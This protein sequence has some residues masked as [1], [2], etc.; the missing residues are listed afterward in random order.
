MTAAGTNRQENRYTFKTVYFEATR[1][2]NLSCPMCMAGSNNR[3]LV[4]ESVKKQLR[5]EE[6]VNHIL[7]PAR[8]IGV[9]TIAWSGG[10]FTL[11]PD[12]VHLV[13]RAAENGFSSGITTNCLNMTEDRL[14]QF[15]IASG[16]TLMISV[17]IDSLGNENAETRD[18]KVDV[19]L[20]V[21]EMCKELGIRSS[22]VVTVGQ[23][24]LGTLNHT[25]QWLEDKR[26]P[27][28]RIPF[29]P[30]GSATGC[31]DMCLTR[32]DMETVIHPA[33]RKR[34]MGYASYTPL[35]L[36]PEVYEQYARGDGGETV[37]LDPAIGCR[38]GACLAISA[39]GEVAP[40]VTMLD[41]MSC[42][43]VREKTFQ[44]IIDESPVF[45][46]L[47]D[48]TQLKGKCGRCRYKFTCG[49]C[50][51]LAHFLEG[52]IMAQD[53]TCFFEPQDETTVSPHEEETNK[54][55]KEYAVMDPV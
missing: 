43:N 20:T 53:P 26:I 9:E 28:S 45:R 7:A 29:V 36:S 30:R 32:R 47:L 3:E 24:N 6:I 49:G 16:G 31:R 33:M 38:T 12:A 2:C 37:P 42:G 5:T 50:R 14:V 44:Q 23:H 46:Q 55:F 17:G 39:E 18:A 40:C 8:E 35:F 22:A 51:S 15:N 52:D 1:L 13:R 19:S 48:R 54:Q 41:T 27:Y 21:L 34:L 10:E 4:K 25:L 11:R